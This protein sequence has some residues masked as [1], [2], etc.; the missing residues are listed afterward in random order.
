M[1][2]R[3]PRSVPVGIFIIFQPTTVLFFFFFWHRQQQQQQHIH[4][5]KG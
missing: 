2:Q 4:S 1:P 5:K 3:V